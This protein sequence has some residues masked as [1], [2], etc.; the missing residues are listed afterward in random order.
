MKP[1]TAARTIAP[2]PLDP[3]PTV[4]LLVDFINPLRFEGA[5]HLREPAQAAARAAATLRRHADAAGVQSIY[6]NDNY[7]L[8]RADFAQ[9]WQRCSAGRGASATMANALRPRQ[10]DFTILKPRHSAFY[11]TPLHLLLQQLQCRS[12]VLTGVAADSCLLFTAMDAYLRGYSL[13]VPAD[14]TAAESEADCQQ[15]LDHMARVMKADIDPS[16]AGW[17]RLLQ[18][19]KVAEHAAR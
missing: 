11:A 1:R 6:A 3:S 7:G 14:C 19:D 13:W 10:R 9:L 5:Q 15:A 2:P 8:W 16:D 4:L 17:R 18:A 12:L